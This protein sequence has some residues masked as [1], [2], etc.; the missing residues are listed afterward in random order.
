MVGD[1]KYGDAPMS[2][3]RI[4]QLTPKLVIQFEVL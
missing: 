1:I 2:A 4:I 3:C